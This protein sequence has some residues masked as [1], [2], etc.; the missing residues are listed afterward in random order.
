M[1][2][3]GLFS[4]F[5]FLILSLAILSFSVPSVNADGILGPDLAT[6][7]ILGASTVTNTGATTL[8]GD[9]GVSP[10]LAITG[11]STITVNGTNA[12]TMGNPFVHAGDVFASMAQ[13]ELAAAKTE[14]G[15]LGAG[16]L[17]P[18]NLGGLTL[19]P[20]VYTVPAGTTNLTGTLT[21]NGQGNLNAFWV[22]QMPSTLITSPG[23]VVNVINTGAGAGLFWNV[24]SSAT[25][26]TTTSFE[27]NILALTSITLDTGATDQCGRALAHTGAVTMD[28]NTL[29]I[30]CTNLGGSTGTGGS[31]GGLSGGLTV[32]PGGGTPIPLP[33]VSAPEPGTMLLLGTGLASFCCLMRL[34]R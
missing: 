7:A 5:S 9:L 26:D 32:P 27:G 2:K 16:T 14:L 4:V 8:T 24:G 34:K 23:S 3:V 21:L 10:G 15:S 12:A 13:S 25:L 18:A 20:G 6:F 29:S 30:G 33:P 22:F 1:R 19:S 17:L 11:E 28:T 31:G